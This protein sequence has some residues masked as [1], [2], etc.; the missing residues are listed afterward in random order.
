MAKPKQYVAWLDHHSVAMADSETEVRT[1]AMA[2]YNSDDYQRFLTRDVVLKVTK[3]SN[4]KLV[5]ADVLAYP[6]RSKA[7]I[8]K[9]LS[10]YAGGGDEY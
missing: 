6:K 3:G 7:A 1:K 4:Q 8:N 2:I 9:L 10:G 5:F